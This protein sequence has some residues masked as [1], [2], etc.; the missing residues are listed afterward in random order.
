MILFSFPVYQILQAMPDHFREGRLGPFLEDREATF[1]PPHSSAILNCLHGGGCVSDFHPKF[2]GKLC[3]I[4][5]SLIAACVWKQVAAAFRIAKTF[6]M[7]QTCESTQDTWLQIIKGYGNLV[8]RSKLE[9]WRR[10]S[11]FYYSLH[12]CHLILNC[13]FSIAHCILKA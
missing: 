13:F 3:L 4:R 6:Q 11:L 2:H 10:F 5:L 1:F 8:S 9:H 7:F 12:L